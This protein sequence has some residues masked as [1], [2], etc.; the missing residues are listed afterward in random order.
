MLLLLFLS[1]IPPLL[2]PPDAQAR[3]SGVSLDAFLV[4]RLSLLRTA[5]IKVG[6]GLPSALLDSRLL[7]SN[8]LLVH[9][10]ECRSDPIIPLPLGIWRVLVHPHQAH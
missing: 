3:N 5:V 9:I 4:L 7:S 6:V 8:L 10:L 2:E 1:S